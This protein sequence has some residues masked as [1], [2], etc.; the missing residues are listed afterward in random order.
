[1]FFFV[2]YVFVFIG[3][4]C[5]HLL[6]YRRFINLYWPIMRFIDSWLSYQPFIIFTDHVVIEQTVFFL[7]Y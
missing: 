1:M 7:S 2:L 3:N 4:K 5:D 6:F